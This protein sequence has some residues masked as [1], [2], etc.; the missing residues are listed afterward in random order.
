MPAETAIALVKLL[1]GL[2]VIAALGYIGKFYDK[3][4]AGVL[5]T[6]PILN[7]I[8]ILTG[9]DPL[10]V[11]RSI[12]AVVVLN[13]IV[14][15][16]M[17]MW[18]D[19]LPRFRSAAPNAKLVVRL[20]VWTAVWFVG[21]P[22]VVL[23][24]DSLPGGG[25]LIAIQCVI[26]AAA[27]FLFWKPEPCDKS[28]SPAAGGVRHH[29]RALFAF[30]SNA[31]GAVRLGLFAVCF[32]LLLFAAHAFESKWVGMFSALPV[33]GLFAVATLSAIEDR[34]YFEPMRDTVLLGPISVIAFNWIYAHVVLALPSEP[35]ARTA[36]GVLAMTVLLAVDAV[37]IVWTTPRLARWVDRIQRARG[38]AARS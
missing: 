28:A 12:Y 38:R 35:F 25:G 21:A 20:I 14:L 4:I 9:S 19:A 16:F 10:A 26:A 17:I 36:F 29:L 13:G 32:G 23:G 33:P 30:W 24:R 18:A 5:L 8:G 3:R 2:A 27:G 22:L 34:D 11:A 15:F 6:F 31:N 7:G 37:L 1:L